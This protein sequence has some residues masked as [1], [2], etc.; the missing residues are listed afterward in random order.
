MSYHQVRAQ[1][2]IHVPTSLKDTFIGNTINIQG[3]H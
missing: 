2:S 3:I 1:N